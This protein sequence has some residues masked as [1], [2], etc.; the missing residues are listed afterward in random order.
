MIEKDAPLIIIG[1]T[2]A[3]DI[4]RNTDFLHLYKNAGIIRFFVGMEN[5]DIKT[6]KPTGNG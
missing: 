4:A 5:T 2:R 1:S 3:D 6:L